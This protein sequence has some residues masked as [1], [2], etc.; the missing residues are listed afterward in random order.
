MKSTLKSVMAVFI[1][2]FVQDI[3][4]NA[5]S[6]MSNEYWFNAQS[7]PVRIVVQKGSRPDRLDEFIENISYGSVTAV[8]LGCVTNEQGGYEV[9]REEK[10][11]EINLSPVS[12]K[13]SKMLLPKGSHG[14]YLPLCRGSAKVTIVA[15]KFAD[16][17][18]WTIR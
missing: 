18:R 12:S 15:V 5:Q 14:G 6:Q 11:I 4:A 1:V 16:G 3:C 8:K 10:D 17:A 9:V 13:E 2:L 7:T